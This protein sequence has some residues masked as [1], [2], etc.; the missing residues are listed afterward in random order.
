M[1]L[2]IIVGYHNVCPI[3]VLEWCKNGLLRCKWLYYFW[4]NILS[5]RTINFL[6]YLIL[7]LKVLSRTYLYRNTTIFG[8][9][10]MRK[11][12]CIYAGVRPRVCA[13]LRLCVHPCVRACVC[14]N[15]LTE[16]GVQLMF[17]NVL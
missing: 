9:D 12:V 5:D 6:S 13:C 17:K 8:F 11:C 3:T 7:S 2:H 14:F 15:A 4:S 10:S 16:F 1:H